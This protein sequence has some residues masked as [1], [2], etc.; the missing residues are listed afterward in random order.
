MLRLLAEERGSEVVRFKVGLDDFY[1]STPIRERKKKENKKYESGKKKKS[2]H[3][4]SD[5]EV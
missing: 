2:L 4:N 3:Y 5:D 1:R